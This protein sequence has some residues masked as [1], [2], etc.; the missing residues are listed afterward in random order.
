M[1]CLSSTSTTHFTKTPQ[2]V[3]SFKEISPQHSEKS[4]REKK[5]KN[6]QF[7]QPLFYPK[8]I[9]GRNP[10]K[11]CRPAPSG[12]LSK[13]GETFPPATFRALLLTDEKFASHSPLCKLL[14]R[15]HTGENEQV[16]CQETV[17]NALGMFYILIL[18]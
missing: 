15:L 3:T 10:W 13:A 1:S 4:E 17:T 5:M 2:T 14:R 9:S 11:K 16:A 8:E 7:S 6:S 12:G 18:F